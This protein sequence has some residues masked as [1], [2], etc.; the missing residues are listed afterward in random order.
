MCHPSIVR[1][2]AAAI[3]ALAFWSSGCS[4]V[5]GLHEG[6]P[7]GACILSSDCAPDEAGADASSDGAAMS[8][9]GPTETVGSSDGAT[10]TGTSTDATTGED[11]PD[12]GSSNLDANDGAL[13]TSD[14]AADVSPRGDSSNAGGRVVINEVKSVN[15]DGVEFYNPGTDPIDIS[16]WYF[17]DN[18]PDG[19][20]HTYKFPAP[21][22]LASH[23]F[24]QVAG[25]AFGLGDADAV[26]LF[27]GQGQEIDRYEWTSNGGVTDSRCP[28]GTGAF[29][30]TT[31]TL[32]A[33]NSCE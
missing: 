17:S 8:D 32:G 33:A 5:L 20:N 29:V 4:K 31:D 24:L 1:A 6:I 9:A 26:I 18:D 19:S 7:G 2:R 15:P 23:A 14:S 28:D 21:T 25:F 12:A 16:G 11:V 10:D 13:A 3:A 22:V 30:A 27:N